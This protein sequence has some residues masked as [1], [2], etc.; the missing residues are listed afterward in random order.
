MQRF[1]L[2]IVVLSA[3]SRHGRSARRGK[4]LPAE[5]GPPSAAPVCRSPA[6]EQ[7]DPP[8]DKPLGW[9]KNTIGSFRLS[10]LISHYEDEGWAVSPLLIIR[11]VRDTWASLSPSPIGVNGFTAEDPPLRLR[12]RRFKEDWEL[13]VPRVGRFCVT[14]VS[15]RTTRRPCGR[16]AGGWRFLGRLDVALDQASQPDCRRQSWQRFLL[17]NSR[18]EPCRNPGG[19]PPGRRKKPSSAAA[20]WPGSKTSF[21]PSMRKT[22]IPST[23]PLAPKRDD[24]SSL[25]ICSFQE[26]RRY[27]WEIQRKPIRWLLNSLGVS[28]RSSSGRT[29]KKAG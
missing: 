1:D 10:E 4:R 23:L 7:C 19:I 12:F 18:P 20:T 21:A 14:R 15:W 29:M 17:A 5:N 8:L 6:A 27:G 28:A 11:D 25:P 16:H 2:G 13:S 3:T 26:L 24:Q 22:T 9:Y